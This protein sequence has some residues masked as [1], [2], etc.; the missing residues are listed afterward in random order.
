VALIGGDGGG[1]T[2]RKLS[3]QE[4]GAPTLDEEQLRLLARLGDDLEDKLGT[5]QDIEWALEDGELYV[6]QARP[7]T[8]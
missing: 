2:E 5:P 3:E 1:T 4:G 7:V 6:L 8:A